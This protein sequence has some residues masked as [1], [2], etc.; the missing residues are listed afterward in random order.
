M[1]QELCYKCFNLVVYWNSALWTDRRVSKWYQDLMKEGMHYS[2]TEHVKHHIIGQKKK[3]KKT[4]HK[5]QMTKAYFMV[6]NTK[7][8]ITVF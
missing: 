6:P 3:E 8:C 5:M 4:A 1:E 2:H 7:E